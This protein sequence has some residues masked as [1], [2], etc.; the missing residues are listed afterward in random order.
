MTLNDVGIIMIASTHC[1]GSG[2]P[3]R[4]TVMTI[5]LGTV[6]LKGS[7]GINLT[8]HAVPKSLC[9]QGVHESLVSWRVT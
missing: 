7:R 6:C 9:I 8:M 3:E 4:P 2:T 1:T 5:A